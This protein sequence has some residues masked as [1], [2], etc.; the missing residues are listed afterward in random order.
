LPKIDRLST[1]EPLRVRIRNPYFA[2]IDGGMKTP[3]YQPDVSTICSKLSERKAHRV[4]CKAGVREG[5][6]DGAKHHT[7]LRTNGRQPPK[8]LPFC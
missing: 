4:F 3:L 7:E 2:L 5:A 1:T 6:H 8:R